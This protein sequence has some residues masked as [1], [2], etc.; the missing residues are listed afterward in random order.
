LK[1]DSTRGEGKEKDGKEPKK[2]S[3]SSA[4]GFDL[5]PTAGSLTSSSI[6]LFSRFALMVMS[7]LPVLSFI[8]YLWR[9]LE[10]RLITTI[11]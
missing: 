11:R 9:V 5:F 3:M 8:P 2:R 6:C 7:S 1:E 10:R 4:V